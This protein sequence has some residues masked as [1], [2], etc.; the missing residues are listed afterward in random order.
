MGINKELGTKELSTLVAAIIRN[1][2]ELLG[3]EGGV[4][5]YNTLKDLMTLASH[6]EH[7]KS[8]DTLSFPF[9][10]LLLRIALNELFPEKSAASNDESERHKAVEIYHLAMELLYENVCSSI[11]K[12]ARRILN[13]SDE[14]LKVTDEKP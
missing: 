9:K 14:L 11:R 7:E 6:L 12:K 13:L 3:Q 10:D 4:E 8:I 1:T 2:K 5:K